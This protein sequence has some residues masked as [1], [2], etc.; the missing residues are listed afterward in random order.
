M[1]ETRVRLTLV[2]IWMLL[3]LPRGEAS[4][5]NCLNIVQYIYHSL[6]L[7][8]RA[9]GSL[10]IAGEWTSSS[11]EVRPGPQFFTRYI[12]ILR[13]STWEGYFHRY[14]D[15]QCSEPKLSLYMRGFYKVMDEP[16]ETIK[17]SSKAFF[18]FSAIELYPHNRHEK[19]IA[20]NT[21]AG[22]CRNTLKVVRTLDSTDVFA[23]DKRAFRRRACRSAFGF[24][25]SEFSGL[26]LETRR[27]KSSKYDKLY[28]GE[29][30]TI[31][32]SRKFKPGSYQLPLIRYNSNNCTKCMKIRFGTGA[33]PPKFVWKP[34]RLGR[35]EGEW[36][37]TTCEASPGGV[38]LTR[39]FKF[40]NSQSSRK[41]E[42]HYY[43][44]VDSECKRRDFELNG[45]GHFWYAAPSTKVK[46]AAEYVF[47]MTEAAITPFDK[48]TT[49]MLNTATPNTCG[50]TGTWKTNVKQ[51][52]TETQ[53]CKLYGI[54]LPK[55]EYDLLKMDTDH[56]D[57][58]LLYVGQRASDGSDPSSP[59]KRATSFQ[60]PLIECSSYKFKFLPPTARPT[61][62]LT[63]RNRIVLSI[64]TLPTR[65]KEITTRRRTDRDPGG[66][67]IH[68]R[69]GNGSNA[70]TQNVE[71]LYRNSAASVLSK[72]LLVLSTVFV[73][74]WI[75]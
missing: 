29:V 65:R 45:K 15:S 71:Y 17:G 23:V 33:R 11:C 20:I 68:S 70:N 19:E 35:L 40:T 4:K 66:Q 38:F 36:A 25:E 13:N 53:G 10:N 1:D 24:L 42:C 49:R 37:S 75:D 32:A 8:S 34:P 50:K 62:R 48:I 14:N 18:N 64:G 56:Q 72:L 9:Q 2:F 31:R 3:V 41:W 12:K 28:F 30:P 54:S 63:T 67:T 52:I 21:S 26:K 16:L 61:T 6:G 73:S 59:S 57:N 58:R 44:Y 43:F 46:G 74:T 7:R 5:D 22:H 39:H 69:N 27:K 60:V 51:D 55:T 47:T